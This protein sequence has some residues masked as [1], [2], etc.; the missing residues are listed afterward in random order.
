MKYRDFGKTGLKVSETGFGAWAIGGAYG[1]VDRQES[2]RALARAQELGCNFVDTA[3]VYGDSEDVLGEFL[4]ERRQ[5]WLVATKYSGQAEGMESTLDQQ[6]RKLGTDYVDL[7]QIHWAPHTPEPYRQ[8]EKLRAAGKAR[9]VGVSLYNAQDIDYVLNNTA[10]DSIQLP[11]SLLDPNP[12]LAK[13]PA[14]RD[15]GIAVIVRSCLKEGFLAGKFTRDTR[16]DD[17]ADQRH[18]W[19]RDKIAELVALSEQ[20]RFVEAE[21]GSLLL[22]AARYPLAFA[23]TSTLILGTKTVAQADLNFGTVPNAQLSPALLQ[24]IAQTQTRL[25][26]D[27]QPGIVQ[28]AAGKL[29]QAARRLLGQR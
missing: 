24:A 21:C 3:A 29:A 23:E 19:S 10:I 25:R 28:R 1:K 11:F 5:Q 18:A 26:L 22:G 4:R 15:S 8:L 9:F 6:L 17:P 7:Y 13:L 12:Y 20:F 14:I 2:L 16:F 27:R